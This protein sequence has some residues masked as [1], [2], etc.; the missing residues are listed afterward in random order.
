MHI[1]KW[2]KIS[3]ITLFFTKSLSIDIVGMTGTSTSCGW[4][5]GTLTK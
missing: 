2:A 3:N 4:V 1:Q 5:D